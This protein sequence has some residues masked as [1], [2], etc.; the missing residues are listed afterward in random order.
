MVAQGTAMPRTAM[1]GIKVD[2]S[3]STVRFQTHDIIN[4]GTAQR[5]MFLLI[6]IERA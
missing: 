6:T 5:E 2:P 4:K 1:A 3:L